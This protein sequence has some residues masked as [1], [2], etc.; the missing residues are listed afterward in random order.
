MLLSSLQKKQQ[1][2]N[3]KEIQDFYNQLSSIDR[4]KQGTSKLAIDP[5][6]L[7]NTRAGVSPS[8]SR[9]QY[10]SQ[11]VR[12]FLPFSLK[13]TKNANPDH[14]PEGHKN[15]HEAEPAARATK[16]RKLDD[17]VY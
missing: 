13:S 2:S 15:V 3:H 5:S 7:L 17:C 12:Q 10:P 9:N 6:S 14:I 4:S 11:M 1:L 8:L 16:R